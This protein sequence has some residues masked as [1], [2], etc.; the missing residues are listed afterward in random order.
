LVA[1]APNQVWTW[2]ITWLKTTV[3]GLFLYAYVIIDIYSRKIVGWSVESA[4]E[5]F[6][7]KELLAKTIRNPASSPNFVHSD[8]GSPMKG[9]NLVSF[10]TKKNIGL[11]FS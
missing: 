2:D 3:L 7:A 5:S 9:L 6:L 4:E 10:L 1:S 8:N 11:S